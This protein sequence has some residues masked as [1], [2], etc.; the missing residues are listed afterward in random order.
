MRTRGYSS[1]HS[2][3][4][5]TALLVWASAGSATAQTPAQPAQKPHAHGHGH[6]QGGMAC[7]GHAMGGPHHALSMAYHENLA[8]F[9]RTLQE[10][11]ALSKTVDVDLARPAVAEMRRSFES[12]KQ[13]HQAHMAMMGATD[14]MMLRR[15]AQ[16]AP[17]LAALGEQIAALEAEVAG[18]KPDP[19]KVSKLAAGILEHCH[20]GAMQPGGKPPRM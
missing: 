1:S 2:V 9:A 20:A 17:A 3:A 19:A 16:M 14:S 5:L 10:Q 4:V 12:I 7:T 15:M 18:S 6:G 11:V 8:N 13:H